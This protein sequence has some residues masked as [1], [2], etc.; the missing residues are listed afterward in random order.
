M[1]YNTKKWRISAVITNT[2]VV[3]KI[4]FKY[5]FWLIIQNVTTKYAEIERFVGCP[6]CPLW[7]VMAEMCVRGSLLRC[8]VSTYLVVPAFR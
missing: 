4:G 8:Y 5:G 3:V 2:I 1:Y 7:V 6:D